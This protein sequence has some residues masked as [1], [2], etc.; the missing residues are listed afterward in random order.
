[1][2]VGLFVCFCVSVS[3]GGF[4]WFS[5]PWVTFGHEGRWLIFIIY[6]RTLWQPSRVWWCKTYWHILPRRPAVCNIWNQ[7]PSGNGWHGSQGRNMGH[8]L[9]NQEGKGATWGDCALCCCSEGSWQAAGMG[10]QEPYEFNKRKC[11]VL[12]LE[13]LVCAGDWLPSMQVQWKGYRGPGRHQMECTPAIWPL[14]KAGQQCPG[15]YGKER[16]QQVEE[17]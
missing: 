16:S 4:S 12:C 2:L 9:L 3:F 13:I 17:N 10:R 5:F 14:G 6:F 11:W 15:L 7:I 1:M 8:L